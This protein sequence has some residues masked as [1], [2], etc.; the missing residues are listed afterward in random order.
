MAHAHTH[1][2]SQSEH[3][4]PVLTDK[5][6]SLKTLELEKWLRRQAHLPSTHIRVHSLQ[7]QLPSVLCPPLAVLV[8]RT[9]L[10]YTPK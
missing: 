7:L 2:V 4:C 5:L 1:T 6:L 9:H 3:V 8:P 10:Q